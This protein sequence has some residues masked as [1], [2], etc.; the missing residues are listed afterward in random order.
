MLY[1]CSYP[2]F[3]ITYLLLIALQWSMIHFDNF[4]GIL[5][6]LN[7]KFC[8]LSKFWSILMAFLCIKILKSDFFYIL[9]HFNEVLLYLNL[10]VWILSKF[11]SSVMCFWTS[12]ETSRCSVGPRAGTELKMSNC[13]FLIEKVLFLLKKCSILMK[14][15]RSEE[16]K[17]KKHFDFCFRSEWCTLW[18]L[19]LYPARYLT[20][21]HSRIKKS[22][23]VQNGCLIWKHNDYQILICLLTCFISMLVLC[24]A[25]L[26]IC[27]WDAQLYLIQEKYQPIFEQIYF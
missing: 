23:I 14:R 18:C 12:D 3:L 2:S 21:Q 8:L 6:C 16:K 9:V 7:L 1:F 13:L 17:W 10:K 22:K 19:K 26:N 27:C 25:H 15:R 4:L 20:V 5:F 11:W 24:D